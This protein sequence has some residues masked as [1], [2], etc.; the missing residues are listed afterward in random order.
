[1]MLLALFVVAFV[2]AV[3]CVDDLV[4]TSRPFQAVRIKTCDN[5]QLRC[6]LPF[7]IWYLPYIPK[8][9]TD[10]VRILNSDN[11]ETLVFERVEV[12]QAGTFRCHTSNVP[13]SRTRTVKIIVVDEPSAC[14]LVPPRKKPAPA[15]PTTTARPTTT[16]Q[17]TTTN[18]RPTTT[19]QPTAP[20]SGS[21]VHRTAPL[22]FL[23]PFLLSCVM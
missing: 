19:A 20:F 1:M 17:P 4:V 8:E 9:P 18:V 21:I 7:G 15:Q 23:I 2:V 16:A 22:S 13:L 12:R 3:N 14:V 5:L 11:T 10:I 6:D